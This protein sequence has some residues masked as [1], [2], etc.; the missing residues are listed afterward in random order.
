MNQI[1]PK[2]VTYPKFKSFMLRIKH[3]NH[4]RMGPDQPICEIL[5]ESLEIDKLSQD[6]Q[7]I[8]PIEKNKVN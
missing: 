2:R 6:F 7:V 1:K 3:L 5:K 8:K 4:W